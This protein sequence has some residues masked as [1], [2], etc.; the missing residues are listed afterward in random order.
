MY[1]SELEIITNC[2]LPISNLIA[3]LQNQQSAIG[4]WQ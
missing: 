3:A 4:N 1:D 2:Q